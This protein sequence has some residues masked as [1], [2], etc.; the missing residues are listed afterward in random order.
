MVYKF[1]KNILKSTFPKSFL[2]KYEENFRKALYP[3][4]KGE[5][6]ECNICKSKLKAFEVLENGNLLCPIC[7]SL[8]RTRRLWQILSDEYL[9]QKGISILDF[10]PSRSIFAK[11][12]KNK[13]IHYFP[14]DFAEEFLATYH[15]DITKIKI[16][17]SKF[18]LIICY[19]ILEHIEE[20]SLAMAE[21]YRVLKPGGICIIQTPFKEGETYEDFTKQTEKERLNYFGQKDHVRIYSVNGLALRLK[22]A[23]FEVD[24]KKFNGNDYFGMSRNETIL[25]ARK[26]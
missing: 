9:N 19:H 3:F 17:N 21:L 5:N 25:F 11:L 6:Y 2:F 10:S 26:G 20:D 22:N 7:G 15:F 18:D 24:I 1:L 14:T 12:K 13:E 16:E 4:Y 23:N 8:P